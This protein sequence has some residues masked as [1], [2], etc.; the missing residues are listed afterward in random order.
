MINHNRICTLANRSKQIFNIFFCTTQKFFFIWM[1]TICNLI[2]HGVQCTLRLTF[3]NCHFQD[4]IQNSFPKIEK[5]PL[6]HQIILPPAM[7]GKIGKIINILFR[8]FFPISMKK[9]L[10]FLTKHITAIKIHQLFISFNCV[11]RV[12]PIKILHKIVFQIRHT[13]WI[14]YKAELFIR[15]RVH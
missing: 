4:F 11:P 15:K 8:I 12:M 14:L 6:I 10:I 1:R 2:L 13:I 5:V 7:I 9:L 3:P